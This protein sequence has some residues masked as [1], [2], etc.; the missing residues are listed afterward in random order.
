M[1]ASILNQ[2]FDKK[3]SKRKKDGVFYT[4]EYITK[5]I[6]ENTLGTLCKE[7]SYLL[8]HINNY[9]LTTYSFIHKN[10]LLAYINN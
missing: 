1:N 4:P 8:S 3:E 10:Y 5:Y 9:L 2:D 7:K 6:L